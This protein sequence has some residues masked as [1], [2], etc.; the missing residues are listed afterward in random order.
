MLLCCYSGI[1]ICLSIPSIHPYN[2]PLYRLSLSSAVDHRFE[3]RLLSIQTYE[4]SDTPLQKWLFSRI[5]LFWALS[6]EVSLAT[7]SS[8]L[9]DFALLLDPFH[10]RMLMNPVTMAQSFSSEQMF[11]IQTDAPTPTSSGS[12]SASAT[13]SGGLGSSMGGLFPE[14]CS[15]DCAPVAQ[16]LTVCE[17]SSSSMKEG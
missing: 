15:D 4:Y 9:E 5:C 13:A 11:S 17:N 8:H 14:Q 7:A 3:D 2:L 16:S 10:G 1:C 12:S 6:R